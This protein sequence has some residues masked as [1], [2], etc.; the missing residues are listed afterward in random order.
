MIQSMRDDN[1]V[2]DDARIFNQVKNF[3]SEN[4]ETILSVS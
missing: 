1:I 2:V 4:I 3:V